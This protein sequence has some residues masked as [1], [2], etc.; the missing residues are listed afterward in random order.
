MAGDAGRWHDAVRPAPA[1]C[2]ILVDVTPGARD[3]A[4]PAGFDPWRGR[5]AVRVRAQAQGGDAN[6]ELAET[7]AAFFGL[8]AGDVAIAA[9]HQG[10]R[11]RL[12]VPLDA[13]TVRGA[14]G[15]ALDARPR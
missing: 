14:L 7:V 11:K 3:P 8:A 9:G 2:D 1:G 4:F 12:R 13:D 5:I 10:R 6:R 15:P